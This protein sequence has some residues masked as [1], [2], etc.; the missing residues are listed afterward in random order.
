MQ[1]ELDA[2]NPPVPISLVAI[3]NVVASVAPDFWAN[4]TAGRDLPWLQDTAE[5]NV[6]G[7]WGANN[8]DLFV[9]DGCNHVTT[10]YPVSLHDLAVPANY[11]ELKA[12]LLAAAEAEAQQH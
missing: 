2:A 11:D 12:L 3:N 10:M 1:D 4:A 6:W 8:W 9:L 5:A 7:T